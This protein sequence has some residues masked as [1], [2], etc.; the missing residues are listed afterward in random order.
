MFLLSP[1]PQSTEPLCTGAI[2]FEA[3][4]NEQVQKFSR[5]KSSNWKHYVNPYLFF[6]T[7]F[8]LVIH[9]AIYN[10]ELRISVQ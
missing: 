6:L 7:R 8:V 1:M 10:T 4:H 9:R 2:V 5:L 3:R